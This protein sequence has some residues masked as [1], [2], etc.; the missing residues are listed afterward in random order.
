MSDPLQIPLFPLSAHIFP[1]GKMALRIFEARYLRMVKETLKA[2]TGFGICM[3]NANGDKDKNQHIYP[4]GTFVKVI[5]FDMLEDGLLGITVEGQYLFT[6][7]EI[8]TQHDGLRVGKVTKLALWSSETFPDIEAPLLQERLV[9]I[10]ASYPELHTLYVDP[11]LKDLSWVVFRWLELLPI[12][13]ADKQQLM[14]QQ[15][16]KVVVEFLES[17]IS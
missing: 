14:T 3:F 8:E 12:K 11:P 1:G 17:L 7:D 10:I 2:Q 13:A 15:N 6:I 4:I 5:D 9:Q 16:P